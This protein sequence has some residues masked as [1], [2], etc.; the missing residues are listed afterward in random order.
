MKKTFVLLS[1]MA[2]VCL[3]NNLFAQ[4]KDVVG[5]SKAKWGMNE[6]QVKTAF[7]GKAVRVE[8]INKLEIAELEQG[9]KEFEQNVEKMK[10]TLSHEKYHSFQ[11]QIQEQRKN[12]NELKNNITVFTTVNIL[13]YLINRDPYDVEFSF[14]NETKSLQSIHLIIKQQDLNPQICTRI[15][16]SLNAKYGDAIYRRV[17]GSLPI[18]KHTWI[19]WEFPSTTTHLDYSIAESGDKLEITYTDARN[20]EGKSFGKHITEVRAKYGFKGIAFGIKYEKV[21]IALRGMA[22]HSKDLILGREGTSFIDITKLWNCK[23]AEKDYLIEFFFDHKDRFYSFEIIWPWPETADYLHSIVKKDL[24]FITEIFRNKYGSPEYCKDFP[25][26]LEIKSGMTSTFCEW[27]T[28]EITSLTGV[29]EEEY[30]YYAIG[31]VIDNM[32]LDE[33]LDYLNNQQ[34]EKAAKGAKD[35]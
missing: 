15:E 24:N 6:D 18:Y 26:V 12:I 4:P 1:I 25:S 11:E 28:N 21:E 33:Y 34:S 30:K 32:F 16:N 8:D 20:S 31:K 7:E 22:T 17:I 14:N 23:I 13:N 5:W 19:L 10:P 9:I 3:A 29:K 35:F 2:I 27:Q